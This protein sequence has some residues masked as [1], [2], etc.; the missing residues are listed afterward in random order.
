MKHP[1]FTLFIGLLL[2]IGSYAQADNNCEGLFGSSTET[3]ERMVTLAESGFPAGPRINIPEKSE[4][5]QFA[6]EYSVRMIKNEQTVV[7]KP[8]GE[9]DGGRETLKIYLTAIVN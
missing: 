2:P 9:A 3:S 7:I 1:L 4:G 5:G 8:A 6:V